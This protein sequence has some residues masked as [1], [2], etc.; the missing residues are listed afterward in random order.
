MLFIKW[1]G[2]LKEH[3]CSSKICNHCLQCTV[4]RIHAYSTYYDANLLFPDF[5]E[6]TLQGLIQS[7]KCGYLLTPSCVPK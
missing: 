7:V 2:Q 6:H 1:Y 3:I 4:C 5:C